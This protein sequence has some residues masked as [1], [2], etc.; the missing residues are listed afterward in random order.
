MGS[1]KVQFLLGALDQLGPGYDPHLE[2]AGVSYYTRWA[3]ILMAL[4]FEFI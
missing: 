3:V 1:S 4:N 2:I